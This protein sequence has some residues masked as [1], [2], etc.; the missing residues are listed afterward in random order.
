MLLVVNLK[1]DWMSMHA[2]TDVAGGK[3]KSDSMSMHAE[4]DV[5]GGKFKVWLDEHAC[6]TMASSI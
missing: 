1:F 6:M 4:I 5:A 2:E 3:F